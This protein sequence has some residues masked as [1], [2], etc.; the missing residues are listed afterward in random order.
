[1]IIMKFIKPVPASI[2]G[3]G[4]PYQPGQEY[5]LPDTAAAGLIATKDP[6]WEQ[7]KSKQ[8]QSGENASSA[9][10]EPRKKG[11]NK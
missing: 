8:N 11:R 7:V 1:M 6:D 2:F 3:V 5:P 9:D 4:G 10:E